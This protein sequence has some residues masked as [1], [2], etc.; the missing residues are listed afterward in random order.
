MVLNGIL[1]TT[2]KNLGD[3]GPL[4]SVIFLQNVQN[5]VLF[6][7][8]FCFLDL[9]IEMIVPALPALFAD[10]SRQVLGNRAPVAGAFLFDKFD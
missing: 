5:Q 6:K 4:I 8:P 7:T 2:F 10:L 9:G 3:F 1:G